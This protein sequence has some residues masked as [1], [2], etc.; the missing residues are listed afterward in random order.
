MSDK[1][2]QTSNFY[3]VWGV[4][5]TLFRFALYSDITIMTHHFA[6]AAYADKPLACC[7]RSP[8]AILGGKWRSN[9]FYQHIKT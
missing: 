3:L 1:C 2:C 6:S 5:S 7:S 9:G 8:N 4:V